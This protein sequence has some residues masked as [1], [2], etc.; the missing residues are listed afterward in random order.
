MELKSQLLC[1]LRGGD[2]EDG[3]FGG[4]GFNH[5]TSE[6]VLILGSPAALPPRSRSMVSGTASYLSCSKLGFLGALKP[7]GTT[8]SKLEPVLPAHFCP[9]SVPSRSPIS[10]LSSTDCKA[11]LK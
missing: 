11:A 3:C 5:F 7:S 4:S 9:W 1:D 8:E 2:R 6:T 10:K